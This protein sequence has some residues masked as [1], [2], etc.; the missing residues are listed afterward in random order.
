MRLPAGYLRILS[1]FSKPAERPAWGAPTTMDA[2][3]QKLLRLLEPAHSPP[4]RTAALTVVSELG[5]RDRQVA[6]ILCKLLN[7]SEAPVRREALQQAGKLRID[8]ALPILLERVT[9]GGEES[10]LAAGAAAKLGA[11]G[12]KALQDLMG[13]VAPGLRRR[14]AGALGAAGT[15]A[16]SS[17]AV[18]ALLDSDPGVIDAA[19]RTLS[20]EIKSQN[21][22]QRRQLGE[23]FIDLLNQSRK[24]APLSVASETAIIRLL[25]TLDDPLAESALWERTQAPNPPALRAAALHALGPRAQSATKENLQRLLNCAQDADFRIAAPALMALSS[26][27]TNPKLVPLWVALLG[28][29]DVAVR[30][31][32]I[33]KIGD[34]DKPE[35]ADGLLQQLGHRDVALRDEAVECLSRL[36]YGHKVLAKALLKAETPDD[37]W[38]LARAQASF[39]S[40]FD[41]DL[42]QRVFKQACAYFEEGD[43]RAEPLLHVLRA[44]DAHQVNEQIAD[45]ALTLRKKKKYELAQRFLRLLARDPACGPAVRLEL[46]GCNLKLSSKDLHAEARATDPC[47][48]QFNNL[49]HSY[50]DQTAEFV[51]KAKWLDPEDL[52]YL[53]FHFAEKERQD[54]EFGGEVLRLAIQRG[55]RSK[56]AK[57]AKS[58]LRGEGLGR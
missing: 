29:P 47:L 34:Q 10:E 7:D 55:G 40:E 13:K 30:R 49:I 45:Y 20:A 35:V 19:A 50:P 48:D 23:Q 2:T 27:P 44:A 21:A 1:I 51:K 9:Q 56:V 3:A 41:A 54:K 18:G 22:S 43:R 5:L 26:L 17:A 12:T 37:A 8:T 38:Q 14:I 4:V 25:A 36:R 42:R 57:D 46:A 32:A 6:D 52:F 58:K 11:K 24:K 28:A 31:A 15:A 39:A 33:K 53:G 16:S